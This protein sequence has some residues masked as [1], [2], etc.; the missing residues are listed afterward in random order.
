[1]PALP[2]QPRPLTAAKSAAFPEAL[3]GR[4]ELQGITHAS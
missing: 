1:M 3:D 2:L 4:H